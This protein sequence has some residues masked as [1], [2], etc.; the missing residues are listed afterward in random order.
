M[1]RIVVTQFLYPAF[2]VP[3]LSP[4]FC[5]QYA[6]RPTG[7]TTAALITVLHVV[8]ELLSDNPYVVVLKPRLHDTT[9]CQTGCEA[10]LT[11]G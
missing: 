5:D 1:E 8:T 2:L 11:T 7:S 9:C 3:P 6:F 10:G 4:N